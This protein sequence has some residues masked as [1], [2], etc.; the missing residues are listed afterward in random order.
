MINC[1]TCHDI[2][3]GLPSIEEEDSFS[4]IKKNEKE[5]TIINISNILN[6]NLLSHNTKRETN[7]KLFKLM[8]EC[9]Y[10]MLEDPNIIEYFVTEEKRFII[11]NHYIIKYY[12]KHENNIFYKIERKYNP[13]TLKLI[14]KEKITVYHV[15]NELIYYDNI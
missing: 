7:T 2:E 14:E 12:L 6:P 13:L 4:K 3:L 1:H 9:A 11:F 10:I 8:E 5:D 15:L